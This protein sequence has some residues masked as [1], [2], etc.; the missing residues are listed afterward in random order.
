VGLAG[1]PLAMT[2]DPADWDRSTAIAAPGQSG[3]PESPHFADLAALWSEGKTFTLAFTER[4]VQAHR[5]VTLAL[6]PK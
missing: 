5:G 4:A 3:S 2:F 1:D 6:T